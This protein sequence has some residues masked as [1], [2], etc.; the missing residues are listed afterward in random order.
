MMEAKA[1]ECLLKSRMR[2]HRMSCTIKNLLTFIWFSFILMH[3]K[4]KALG[5]SQ[6]KLLQITEK[7][8]NAFHESSINLD[9]GSTGKENYKPVSAMNIDAK[10]KKHLQIA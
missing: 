9:K 4:S 10:I 5:G 6:Y 2:E 7:H 8:L 3:G 1:L